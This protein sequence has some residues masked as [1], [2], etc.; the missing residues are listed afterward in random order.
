MAMALAARIGHIPIQWQPPSMASW[1]SSELGNIGALLTSSLATI[2]RQRKRK[3]QQLH[4]SD[5]EAEYFVSP[6][7]DNAM[8]SLAMASGEIKD[9]HARY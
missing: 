1:S 7:P 6:M 3:F 5:S 8:R 9:W 2:G 4:A